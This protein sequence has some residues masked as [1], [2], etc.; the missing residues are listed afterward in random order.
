MLHSGGTYRNRGTEKKMNQDEHN[1]KHS[2][3]VNELRSFY[4]SAKQDV[5][6]K[7]M[8]AGKF[9]CCIAAQLSRSSAVW[10]SI[11]KNK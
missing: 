6:E 4:L 7:C 5:L 2:L 9:A 10:L 11:D 3:L 1:L 8:Y